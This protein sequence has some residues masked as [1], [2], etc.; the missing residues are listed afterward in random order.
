[1]K[2]RTAYQAAGSSEQTVAGGGTSVAS[3]L[4]DAVADKDRLRA[5]RP[6]VS[7][8]GLAFPRFF[9]EASVDPFDEIEWE[10]RD[11][12]IGSERGD[13]VFEQRGVEIPRFWSQ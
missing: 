2:E 12:V 8:P 10:L 13:V 1:M 9:T 4:V 7:T 11:A 6:S 3:G 5:K